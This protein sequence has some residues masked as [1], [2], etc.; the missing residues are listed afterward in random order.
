M[1]R[2]LELEQQLQASNPEQLVQVILQIAARHPLL[3][4]EIEDLLH[5]E[6]NT[7]TTE[8]PL[9]E[10]WDFGGEE[11]DPSIL[12]VQQSQPL[13]FNLEMYS[14]RLASYDKRLQNNEPPQS[15]TA[16]LAEILEEAA[17][18]AENRDYN[19]ALTLYALI[20]DE[21][22]KEHISS[23][24]II[25]DEAIYIVTPVLATLLSE[26]NNNNDLIE[27]PP[28]KYPPLFTASIRCAW[29]ERLFALWI[30]RLDART[31]ED[32]IQEI[33]LNMIW[34]E[35]ISFLRTLI[36]RELQQKPVNQYKNIVDF[37]LQYKTRA[38][39]HFLKDI[40]AV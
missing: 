22:L 32:E 39:E 8:E 34:S 27:V 31:V 21:R 37:T 9:T 30:K 36:Q 6:E 5:T 20:I 12:L 2:E 1:E 26:S 17:R 15:I 14:K 4:T 38:L 7:E 24:T 19:V 11:A 13:P 25:L 16:D 18:R 28:H 29:I 33:L 23:L 10:D 40:P 35:D 3:Q